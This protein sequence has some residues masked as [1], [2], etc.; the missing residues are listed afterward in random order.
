MTV[1]MKRV[2]DIAEK[3]VKAVKANVYISSKFLHLAI[4]S[5]KAVLVDD[6]IA[7]TIAADGKNIYYNPFWIIDKYHKSVSFLNR[8]FV[9]I[10]F[11]GVFKHFLKASTKLNKLAWDVSCDICVEKIVD[12]LK[13]SDFSVSN[14]SERFVVYED[15]L[16]KIP[17][18]SAEHIY[19]ILINYDEQELVRLKQLFIKDDHSLW[20]YSSPKETVVRDS[21]DESE[22]SKPDSSESKSTSSNKDESNDQANTSSN[23]NFQINS[24]SRLDEFWSNVGSV[25][26]T[27]M[28]LFGLGS[29]IGKEVGDLLR[30]LKIELHE[31]YD[32][33]SFLR[34]FMS[35]KEVMKEDMDQFDYIY[36]SLGFKLFKNM[37]LIEYLEYKEEKVIDKLVIAIDT[38]GSTM[39]EPVKRFLEIAYVIVQEHSYKGNRMELHIIQA[40][41]TVQDHV[42]IKDQGDFKKYMDNFALKGGGGTDFRPVFTY[43]DKKI[44]NN[45]LAGLRGLLYFSDG[46]GTYPK[47]RPKYETAFLYYDN[48]YTDIDVPEWIIKIVIGDEE[49]YEHS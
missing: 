48:F 38:S 18:L 31:K 43:V 46:Y 17:I 25:L 30:M 44:E 12:D 37:P 33:K 41:A 27:E 11:H 29:G 14:Q 21:S 49:L 5:Y 19:S 22:D 36:Y 13:M 42:I 24:N 45:E 28:E 8:T 47:S 4:S 15:F 6:R 3:V 7:E 20:Y 39:G 34:K 32:L 9:H 35:Y 2:V 40:D 16:T 26:L 10:I 1:D 23:S